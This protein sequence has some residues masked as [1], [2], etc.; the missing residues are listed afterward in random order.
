M[1]NF[2]EFDSLF[3]DSY[4]KR[5]GTSYEGEDSVFQWAKD[6]MDLKKRIVEHTKLSNGYF[7]STVWLGLNHNYAEGRPLI[8]E[9]MVF[10]SKTS[11]NEIDMDRYSTEEEA[12]EGHRRMVEEWSKK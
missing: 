6:F 11:F 1:K 3:Q 10:S 2:E 12:K 7:V 4:F 9:T 8:F 5:D